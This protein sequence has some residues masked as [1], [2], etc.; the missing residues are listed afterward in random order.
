MVDLAEFTVFL[1]CASDEPS[2]T[3]R[4]HKNGVMMYEIPPQRNSWIA[5]ENPME[6]RR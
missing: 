2:V 4:P 3:M 5:C 6:V 1:L